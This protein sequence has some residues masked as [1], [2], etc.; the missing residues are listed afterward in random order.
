[1]GKTAADMLGHSEKRE[2]GVIWGDENG[3]RVFTGMRNAPEITQILKNP[4]YGR[5]VRRMLLQYYRERLEGDWKAANVLLQIGGAP[6]V[7]RAER[8]GLMGGDMSTAMGLYYVAKHKYGLAA[9]AMKRSPSTITPKG[10]WLF[11][12]DVS[13]LTSVFKNEDAAST[14]FA[15][16]HYDWFQHYWES[17][18]RPE[19]GDVIPFLDE[20]AKK[21]IREIMVNRRVWF[22]DGGPEGRGEYA[23][24]TPQ[25]LAQYDD[26][27]ILDWIANPSDED[28][29]D[30]VFDDITEALQTAG[31]K[32]LEQ[33]AI[34]AVYIG[35]IKE[36]AEAIGG[37]E[38][39][40]V[41]HPTKK[42]S[43]AFA[44]FV[45]WEAINEQSSKFQEEHGYPYDGSLESL[46]VDINADTAEVNIE[47]LEPG[48]RDVNKD[49]AK[50]YAFDDLYEL[51]APD[52]QPGAPNYEDPNQLT[53]P[54]AE[55]VDDPEA[56]PAMFSGVPVEFENR[57]KAI[58]KDSMTEYHY[59][60]R[61]LKF[62]LKPS[63]EYSDEDIDASDGRLYN[64]PVH[65]ILLVSYLP[66]P[67]PDWGV[68]QWVFR[69]V[70][71]T[72]INVFKG[73]SVANDYILNPASLD[74]QLPEDLVIFQFSLYDTPE[75]LLCPQPAP[76]E[77]PF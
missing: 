44:V 47:H 3:L 25:V 46:A 76:E 13:D 64:R 20:K 34:D 75:H 62:E 57:V 41:K 1:L 67:P 2:L 71:E 56:M 14:V 72:A 17:A 66:E 23:V 58:L 36:A 16:D 45:P 52:P 19:V 74:E 29:E 28:K 18:N 68:E 59:T 49:Y 31:V 21:H 30:G 70:R 63:Q 33:T 55:G 37:T 11:Y 7:R 73:Q 12:D 4:E 77:V 22:P 5:N 60:I 32:M 26:D 65:R 42:G 35:Y 50:D 38:H 48:W 53:L 61:D 15:N 27:T 24:L 10:V 6:E 40:W 9:K 51:E 69:K 39:K 8:R 54:M 43:D